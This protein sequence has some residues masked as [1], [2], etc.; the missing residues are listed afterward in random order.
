MPINWTTS[1]QS[2]VAQGIKVLAYGE[3]GIGKTTLCATAPK[4]VILSAESGLLTLSKKNLERI[5]GVGAQDITYDIP[6]MQITSIADLD[7]AYR[8][9]A[10]SAHAVNFDTV[11]LDSV[12]EIGEQILNNA[13][14]TVKDPRQAYGELIEKMETRIRQFRDLPRFNVYMAAKSE[15]IKDEMTGN[16]MRGPS[17]PGSKLGQKL[18]YFFDEVFELCVNKDKDGKSYRFLRTQP[19][20]QAIAKDRSGALAEQEWPHLTYVF[21]KIREGV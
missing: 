17:M 14:R 9:F 12:S 21:N 18:P 6:V 1:S 16:I 8:W 20:V 15:K 10:E 5:Y 3:S 2:N 13:K 19:D 7:D 11:C 4:P